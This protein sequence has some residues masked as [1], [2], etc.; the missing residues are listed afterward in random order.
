MANEKG[1]KS[2]QIQRNLLKIKKR[3]L[4][5]RMSLL[6]TFLAAESCTVWSKLVDFLAV[7]V[8]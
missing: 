4:K 3:E 8:K 2:S 6:L 5:R 7:E 1:L